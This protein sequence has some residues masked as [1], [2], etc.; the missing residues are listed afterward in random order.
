MKKLIIKQLFAVSLCALIAG[1]GQVD[2]GEAGFFTRWGEVISKEPLSEGLHFY[3]PW[4]TDLVTYDIKNQTLE[5]FT[6]VFTKDVQSMKVKLAVTYNIEKSK[7]IKLHSETGRRYGQVLIMPSVLGATKDALG[8]M[9]AGDIV[10]SREQATA[11]IMNAIKGKLAQYG[12]NIVLVNIANIDY[13]DA[14]EK[15]VEEKQV[16]LQQSQK[17]KN[18]TS[19]LREVAEQQVV[20]AEADA[21]AKVLESEAEAKAI[22]VKAEAEAKSIDMRNK[23]LAQSRALIEYET[24]KTWDGKLPVQMLG[25][26]PVPFLSIGK[27]SGK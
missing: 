16:A 9:E 2:T 17:E 25:G 24:V 4:G 27:E 18:N 26:A 12:I 3:E 14:F 5:V 6:D 23:A 13:S 8:K 19:R 15:A 7:V 21:K 10:S 20:K 11:A 1:C 22:L